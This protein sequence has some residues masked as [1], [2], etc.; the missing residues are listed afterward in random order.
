MSMCP[1][2]EPDDAKSTEGWLTTDLTHIKLLDMTCAPKILV[3]D[4]VKRAL[5]PKNELLV[6]AL[7]NLSLR[8]R[9]SG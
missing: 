2:C 4:D 9:S 8:P 1:A 7:R 3:S 6:Q 5:E